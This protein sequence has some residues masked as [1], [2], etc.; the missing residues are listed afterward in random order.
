MGPFGALSGRVDTRGL[1]WVC[2]RSISS[3]TK[4]PKSGC[5]RVLCTVGVPPLRKGFPP[6][7]GGIPWSG[8]VET[9]EK[10][11]FFQ[12]QLSIRLAQ[13]L[14][15]LGSQIDKEEVDRVESLAQVAC[16]LAGNCATGCEWM[17]DA[18]RR[19]LQTKRRSRNR[20]ALR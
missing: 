8:Q 17:L 18:H 15:Q 3:L 12:T 14:H 13:E 19:A 20:S 6:K 5:A 7:Y 10:S 9:Y 2:K 16:F 1:G 11:V 4:A